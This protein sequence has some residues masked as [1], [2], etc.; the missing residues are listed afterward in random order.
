MFINSVDWAAEQEDLLNITPREKTLRTFTPPTNAGF[1]IMIIVAVL[2]LPGMVVF[3]GVSSWLTRR[4]K[5]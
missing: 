5:G 2:V 3:A 4:K 1:I